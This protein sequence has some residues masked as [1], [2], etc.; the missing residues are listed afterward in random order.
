MQV[1]VNTDKN[2]QGREDLVTRVQGM[3]SAALG[4]Y[5]DRITRVEVHLSDENSVKAGADD[6]RCVLEARLAGMRP[7]VASHQAEEL[8]QAIDGALEKLMRALESDVGR[9]EEKR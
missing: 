1:Q 5:V 8:P 6:K 4:R 7:V 9:L 2:I 3:V